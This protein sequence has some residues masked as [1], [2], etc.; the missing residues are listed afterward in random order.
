MTLIFNLEAGSTKLGAA[1]STSG[2]A[3]ANFVGV[4][5]SANILPNTVA[6]VYFGVRGR[7]VSPHTFRWR[8]LIEFGRL[9]ECAP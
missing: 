5:G 9:S 6:A 4:T 3:N 1:G 2:W 8:S 7:A